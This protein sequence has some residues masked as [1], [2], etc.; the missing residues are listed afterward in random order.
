MGHLPVAF[1]VRCRFPNAGSSSGR[2]TL[3]ALSLACVGFLTLIFVAY[4]VFRR[5]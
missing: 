1:W 3:V 5:P 4:S 2:L